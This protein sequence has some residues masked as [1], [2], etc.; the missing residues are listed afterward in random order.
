MLMNKIAQ[1]HACGKNGGPSSRLVRRMPTASH[2]VHTLTVVGLISAACML[3]ACGGKNQTEMGG[4]LKKI[5]SPETYHIYVADIPQ[6]NA[7]DGK[8]IERIKLGMKKNQIVYLLGTSLVQN[9]F[10]RDRWDYVYYVRK[11]NKPKDLRRVTLYFEGD[12]LVRIVRYRSK[13]DKLSKR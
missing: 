10:R 8:K 7:I 6:G 1:N 11:N 12:Q 4:Y 9:V 13:P 2:R 5:F 3:V